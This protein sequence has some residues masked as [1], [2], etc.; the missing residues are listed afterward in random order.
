MESFEKRRVECAYYLKQAK[1]SHVENF[2][3]CSISVKWKKGLF[4]LFCTKR[5]GQ[6]YP[7]IK[8][9]KHF[10]VLVLRIIVK[11]VFNRLVNSL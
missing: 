4:I 2:I 8:T 9:S 3:D 5:Q 11:I 7:F 6:I 1:F 10:D